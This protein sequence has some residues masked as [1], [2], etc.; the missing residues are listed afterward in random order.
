MT[1]DVVPLDPAL[2][3]G[4]HGLAAADDRDS[5]L[6]IGDGPPP[7]TGPLPMTAVRDVILRALELGDD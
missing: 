7:G 3:R 4:S 1:L 5:P 6:W 2:V